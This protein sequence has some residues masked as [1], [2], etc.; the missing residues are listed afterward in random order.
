MN[1]FQINGIVTWLL[2]FITIGANAQNHVSACSLLQ[3]SELEEALG[4]KATSFQE[5]SRDF[6]TSKVGLISVTIRYGERKPETGISKEQKALELL[7]KQG[8]QISIKNEGDLTVSSAIPPASYPRQFWN[9]TASIFRN[10]IVVAV[11]LSAE[12]KV[13]KPSSDVA[14]SLVKKAIGRFK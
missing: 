12:I 7:K 11:E 3:T 9:I 8:W 4:G 13:S 10:G 1:I 2:A 6:C 5:A 14:V